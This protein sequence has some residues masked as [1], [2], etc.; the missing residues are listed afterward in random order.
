MFEGRAEDD[1]FG[2]QRIVTMNHH[3]TSETH[4][5]IRAKRNLKI[6]HDVYKQLPPLPILSKTT[7][8]V[9]TA[10]TARCM[11]LE[12]EADRA[13]KVSKSKTK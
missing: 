3:P 8:V 5:I 6:V 4:A 10:A 9:F 12:K 2:E 7:A 11:Y 13:E 1:A